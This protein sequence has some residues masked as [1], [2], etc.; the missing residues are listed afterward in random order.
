[1][2]VNMVV[3]Y[4]MPWDPTE[5]KP[6]VETY[7]HRSGFLLTHIA[8]GKN[9]LARLTLPS[10]SFQSEGLVDLVDRASVSRLANGKCMMPAGPL[11]LRDLPAAINMIYDKRSFETMKYIEDTLQSP[12]TGIKTDDFEAMEKVSQES[13]MRRFALCASGST[14]VTAIVNV[15]ALTDAQGC[16]E[17]VRQCAAIVTRQ[18]RKKAVDAH[19]TL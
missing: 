18:N 1:M 8:C 10:H 13:A 6:D 9:E 7:L 2:S 15:L 12:I 16:F 14:E 19:R 11:T 5:K 4:D 3:N 17:E